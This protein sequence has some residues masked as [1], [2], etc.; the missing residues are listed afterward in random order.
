M[1]K[2]GKRFDLTTADGR[3]QARI[4]EKAKLSNQREPLVEELAGKLA[5]AQAALGEG[6]YVDV[7][8]ALKDIG[9]LAK[10]LKV[11]VE[12]RCWGKH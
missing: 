3:Y 5:S 6:H 12:M 9:R 4:V 11:I 2:Y 10:K 8:E 7:A 1:K